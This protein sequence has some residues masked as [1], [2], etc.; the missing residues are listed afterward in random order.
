VE[1]RAWRKLLGKHVGQLQE[2][3]N[4]LCHFS[5]SGTKE[6]LFVFTVIFFVL[7][8]KEEHEACCGGCCAGLGRVVRRS[9][10]GTFIHSRCQSFESLGMVPAIDVRAFCMHVSAY[11]PDLIDC[12]S[13]CCTQKL[14]VVSSFKPEDCPRRSK[15]TRN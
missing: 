7:F 14:K 1:Q 12:S 8:E 2:R 13:G 3:G 5:A 10:E 15:V 4:A 11:M 9:E 6:C